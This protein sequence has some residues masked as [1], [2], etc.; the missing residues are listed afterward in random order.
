MAGVVEIGKEAVDR[1][2]AGNDT[3]DAAEQPLNEVGLQVR[4]HIVV[5]A[6][7]AI[8]SE[9]ITVGPPGHAA[10]GFVLAAGEQTPPIYVENTDMVAVIGSDAGLAY[11]W[12]A[13]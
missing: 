1:F 9:T 4:K 2:F 10:D 12:I 6:S 11:S 7:A 5:R 8:G 3:V 13:N